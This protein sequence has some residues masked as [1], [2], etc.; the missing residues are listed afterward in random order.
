MAA[1]DVSDG[2]RHGQH[3]ESEGES[4]AGESDADGG[5]AGGENGGAASAK[6]QPERS[7]EFRCCTFT[8]W[9]GGSP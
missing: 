1:G 8:D 2:K 9:H 3:G 6:H 5:K 7:K 4:D